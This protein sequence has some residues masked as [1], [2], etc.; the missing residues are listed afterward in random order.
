M[1]L[2]YLRFLRK[3]TPLGLRRRSGEGPVDHRDR[4][5]AQRPDLQPS[6]DDIVERYLRLRYAGIG[7][8]AERDQLRQRVQA[9]KP[10]RRPPGA[11]KH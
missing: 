6:I 3:L 9:F 11:S 1:A 4:I 5:V 10:R 7:G 8:N 2:A